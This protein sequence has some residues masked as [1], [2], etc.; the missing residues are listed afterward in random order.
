MA[1]YGELRY[2]TRELRM[3]NEI[4]KDGKKNEKIRIRGKDEK[5]KSKHIR[6]EKEWNTSFFRQVS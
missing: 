1:G 6:E 2:G 5:P 3:D 4:G